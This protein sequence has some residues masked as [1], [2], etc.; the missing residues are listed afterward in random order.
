MRPMLL[1]MEMDPGRMM[2]ISLAAVTL[3]IGVKEVKPTE[4]GQ[5]LGALC[6]LD[7]LKGRPPKAAVGTEMMVMAFFPDGL[8][9][10][11]LRVIR[12]NGME[13]PRLKAVLTPV[14]RLWNCGQLYAEL[15]REDTALRGKGQ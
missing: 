5:T 10:D 1:C 2:R 3:G 4:W 9:E 7:S 8:I 13:P 11:F 12:R 6:G 15:M 14:N